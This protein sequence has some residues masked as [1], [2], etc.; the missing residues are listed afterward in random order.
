M[1]SLWGNDIEMESTHDSIS[2]ITTKISSPKKITT[3]TRSTTKGMTVDE[4]LLYVKSEVLRILGRYANDTETIYTKEDLA[5]YIDAAI[6]NGIIAYDTE[7]NNSLDPITCKIMGACLYTP[8]QKHAYVPINHIDVYTRQRLPNQVT[9]EDLSIELE[10]LNSTTKIVYHNAKFDYQVTKCATNVQLRIDYDTLIA[11]KMLDENRNSYKLKTLYSEL[12]DSTA[13]KY[14]IE[15]LF[16]GLEYAIVPPEIFALYAA[17]DSYLTYGLYEN[18]QSRLNTAENKRLKELIYNVEIPT[19]KVVAEME[20]TGARIDVEYQKKLADKLHLEMDAIMEKIN[21]EL[22]KIKPD[23]AKWRLSIDANKRPKAQSKGKNKALPKTKNEQLPEE[24]NIMSNQQLSIIL[25]DVLGIQKILNK[26][27]NPTVDE[28]A[29]SQ[30]D[31]PIAKLV[32]ELR[33]YQKLTSTYI[34]NI[35]SF[36]N[37]KTGRVHT[38]YNQLGAK[39][40]RMSSSE[41]INF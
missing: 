10:R 32:T 16:D 3:T 6:E 39:T 22:D 38:H 23:I 26:N 14:D 7:T 20:L 15:S 24:I 17:T 41:P 19:I 25:Y 21:A 4:R 40:G 33:T 30:I 29:L 9:E 36:I 18:Q 31:H 37:P 27:G 35:L 34:D 8:G 13:E 12:I 28:E 2:K 1:V 11:E 5:N